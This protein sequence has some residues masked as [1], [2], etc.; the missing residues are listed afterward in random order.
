QITVPQDLE[1]DTS[2]YG[3]TTVGASSLSIGPRAAE[4]FEAAA[5]SIAQEI[6]ADPARRAAL[7]GCEPAATDDPCIALFLQSFG[8]RAFRRP[9]AQDELASYLDVVT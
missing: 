7:V 2:L 3:F 6:F 9:L 8:R 4:Q 5:L 1:V